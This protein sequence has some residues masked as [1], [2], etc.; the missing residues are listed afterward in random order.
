MTVLEKVK[1]LLGKTG[2]SEDTLLNLLIDNATTEI[3]TYVHTTY[4][5]IYEEVLIELVVARYNRISSE[6][7][8]SE[9][10]T[11]A[12]FTYDTA[13]E[14]SILNQL[15]PLRKIRTV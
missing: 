4:S 9:S 5:D 7:V 11:G 10:Y 12:T 3:E 2:S 1:L 14:A 13:Y 15:K 8:Q 6:G